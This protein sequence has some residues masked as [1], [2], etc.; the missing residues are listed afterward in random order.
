MGLDRST[1]PIAN[2]YSKPL[3]DND[4]KI[5]ILDKT[6]INIVRMV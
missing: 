1:K 4:K 5:K 6:L 2:N 3:S